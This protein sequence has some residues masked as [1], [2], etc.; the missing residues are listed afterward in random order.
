MMSDMTEQAID[1]AKLNQLKAELG[2]NFDR[3]LGYYREDGARTI[4]AIAGALDDRSAVALVRPAHT[5]KGESLQFGAVALAL[6]AERIE[7]AARDAVERHSFPTTIDA[8]VARLPE[9]FTQ[10]L[11]VFDREAQ[12]S[13][14]RKAMGFGRK[15]GFGLR[16]A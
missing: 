6:V 9:L 7:K 2:G 5:L 13:P 16:G 4:A 11:A 10:A 1:R 8:D 3:I 14:V 15:V 12:S